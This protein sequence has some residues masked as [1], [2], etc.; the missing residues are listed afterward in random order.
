M[1]S[2]L[3]AHIERIAGLYNVPAALGVEMTVGGQRPRTGTIVGADQMSLILKDADG[4]TFKAHPTW[5]ATY[6][7]DP[8]AWAVDMPKGRVTGA[9]PAPTPGLPEDDRPVTERIQSAIIA[10]L[11]RADS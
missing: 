9:F 5:K 11:A 10:E 6:H 4:N 1:T 8:P 7:E 3:A 2:N